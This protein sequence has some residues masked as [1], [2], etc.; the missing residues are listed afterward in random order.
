MHV[1][2]V[3]I[4]GMGALT[5][6]GNTVDEFSKNVMGGKCGI[7]FIT[8][9]DASTFKVKVAAELKNFDATDYLEKN[10]VRKMD[11]FT[12]YAVIAAEQ[13]V[14][15]SGIVGNIAPE[16][17]GVYIG[18]G[19]GGMD[20][21]INQTEKLLSGGE[22][23]VSPFFIPMM[24]SNMASGTVAI[25]SGA[26]GPCLPIVTACS[27]STHEIG[28]AFRAIKHGYA[29]AIIAGGAEATINP[30]CVAG[31]TNMTALS[32][33][34]IPLESSIPFDLRR[35][36]F[37]V[38][39]GSAVIVLEEMEHAKARGAKIYAEVVGYGNSCDAYHITAPHPDAEGAAAAIRIALKEASYEDGMKI[40]YNAHGTSTPLNDKAETVAIKKVFEEKAKDIRISSTKSMTGH[41][42]GAAGAIEAIVCALTL[43]K[44]MI[45][46]T[47]GYK[48][49]DPDC[50]LDY[51]PNHCVEAEVDLA[52]STSLGFGGHNG[53]LAFRKFED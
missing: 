38:G 34:N 48:E 33:K 30:L 40:Y 16:R 47:I 2:R 29:D 35:D 44:G 22:R 4:T 19:I 9:F 43:S 24:I 12:Q 15:D 36:G 31:F 53:V 51:T 10:E 32:T 37:V 11:A 41:M 8:K 45:A 3:V 18:S 46:P 42:L 20:T 7:D 52:I 21:F 28:E 23:K 1:K 13:A 50:D 6:I 39:E 5:P 27:T 25:R 17:L 49:K 14:T 26:K